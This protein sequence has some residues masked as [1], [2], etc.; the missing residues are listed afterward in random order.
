MKTAIFEIFRAGKHT[1]MNGSTMD[2]NEALL[3]QIVQQYDKQIFTADLVIGHPKDGAD[4]YGEVSRLFTHNKSLFAECKVK[5]I[6]EHLILTGRYKKISSSFYSPKSPKNPV[7]NSYYLRHVGFLGAM[8]PAVKGMA[9]PSNA[10]RLASFNES[11]SFNCSDAVFFD[12]INYS[13][14]ENRQELHQKALHIQHLTGIS[15]EQAIHQIL[16]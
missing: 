8:P 15:Y 7:P 6:L 11:I 14:P 13:D 5:P 12:E 3:E 1:A 10:M 16:Y 4:S 9:D 2:W